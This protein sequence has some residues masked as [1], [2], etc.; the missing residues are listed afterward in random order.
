MM[1]GMKMM[2]EKDN[3]DEGTKRCKSC[4]IGGPGC[5]ILTVA[6]QP[7]CLYE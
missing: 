3:D 7:L 4:H 1:T 2:V 6:F 5:V